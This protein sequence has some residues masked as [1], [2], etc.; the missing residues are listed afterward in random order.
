M[1]QKLILIQTIVVKKPVPKMTVR[2]TACDAI[3]FPSN[4]RIALLSM[5]VCRFF[6][7]FNPIY[8]NRADGFIFNLSFCSLAVSF[9]FSYTFKTTLSVF[10]A[11]RLFAIKPTIGE[12]GDKMYSVIFEE[13][14]ATKEIQMLGEGLTNIHN[15][16]SKFS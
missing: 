14:T 1:R 10:A 5:P 3:R 13:N 11:E 2:R 12:R 6:C 4:V 16:N 15:L 8:N 9:I 7:L